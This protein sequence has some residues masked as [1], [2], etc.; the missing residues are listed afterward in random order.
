MTMD[1]F[2]YS[3]ENCSVGR[4]L[5]VVGEKW[6]FLVLR[7]AFFGIKRFDEFVELL[8]CSRPVLSERLRKLVE[9]GLLDSVPYQESGQRARV[10]YRLTQKGIELFPAILALMRWGDRWKADKAGPAVEI[11]HR[12]C[13]RPVRIAMQCDRHGELGAIDTQAQPGPGARQRAGVRGER[14]ASP[15]PQRVASPKSQG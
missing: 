15:G 8:D 9:E 11:V 6:T 3:A 7:E 2:R 5:D 12:G 10:E 13:G 1:R 14:H 4:T